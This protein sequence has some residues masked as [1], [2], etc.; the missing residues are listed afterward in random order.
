MGVSPLL[1]EV[2]QKVLSAPTPS[3]G[4]WQGAPSSR[5]KE[6]AGGQCQPSVLVQSQLLPAVIKWGP[7]SLPSPPGSQSTC[8][9][10]HPTALC[11]LASPCLLSKSWS[12]S[13]PNRLKSLSH[14]RSWHTSHWLQWEHSSLFS[15]LL[16]LLS[17]IPGTHTHWIQ[18]H[19]SG[20][21]LSVSHCQAP[22]PPAHQSLSWFVELLFWLGSSWEL[23]VSGSNQLHF[24]APLSVVPP[25]PLLNVTVLQ[26]TSMSVHWTCSATLEEC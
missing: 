12:I 11:I 10:R 16:S 20:L 14:F 19:L 15:F 22:K 21:S 18:Q 3:P 6:W 9:P 26:A 17:K 4:F 7:G 8:T 5:A 23:G 25:Q 24:A 13:I 2:S 1:T